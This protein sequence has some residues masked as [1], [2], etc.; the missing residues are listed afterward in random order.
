MKLIAQIKLQPTETQALWLKK[1]LE[2]A[3]AACNAISDIAM[4]KQLFSQYSLHKIIYQSMRELFE[5]SAQIIAFC[6]NSARK[7]SRKNHNEAQ[8]E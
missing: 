8:K 4:Q 1:T 7:R 5:L 2:P 3:N 6:K